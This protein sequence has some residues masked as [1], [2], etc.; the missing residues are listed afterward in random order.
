MT[1]VDNT[2]S[3]RNF[4]SPLNFKFIVKKAPNVNFFVQ[5]VIIPS[6]QLV[7]VD[8]SNPFVRT[9]Y[10]GD[11]ID[12]GTLGLSFK[13]DEDLQNYLEIFNWLKGLGFPEKF[14][15]Y[16]DLASQPSYSGETLYSDVSLIINASTKTSNYELTFID[17][18]PISL[19]AINFNTVDSSVNYVD[20][21][22]QFKYTYFTITNI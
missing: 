2:P 15:Q 5:K 22:V 17:A 11:H 10:A 9:P 1:A 13:V 12:F 18:F 21:D 6:V 8:T 3:N 20:A 16:D 4:L 7:Q 19:S 14:Q